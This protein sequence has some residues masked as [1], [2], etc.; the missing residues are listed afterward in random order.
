MLSSAR[1]AALCGQA[2]PAAYTGI[3][4]IRV[5]DPATQVV[6]QVFFI[7]DPASTETSGAPLGTPGTALDLSTTPVNIHGALPDHVSQPVVIESADWVTDLAT[8]RT[9][10]EIRVEQPGDFSEYALTV[11]HDA[12]DWVFRTARFS[13]KQACPTRFDCQQETEC[14]PERGPRVNVDYTARDFDSLRSAVLD[15]AAQHYPHWGERVPADGGVMLIEVLCAL[16]DEFSYMQDR[17]ARE[18]HFATATQRRSLHHMARLVDYDVDQGSSATT[19]LTL[20]LADGGGLNVA[21]VVRAGEPLVFWA[22]TESTDVVPFEVLVPEQIHDSYGDDHFWL[23]P[24]WNEMLAYTPDAANPCIPEGS[25]SLYIAPMADGR[26]PL[27]ETL[28]PESP[29]SEQENWIGRTLILRMD[30]EDPSRPHRVWVV[31]VTEVDVFRDP[32][33]EAEAG[34][35]FEVTK[36]TWSTDQALPFE[37]SLPDAKIHG[38]NVTAVAGRTIVK[39]VRTGDAVPATAQQLQQAVIREGARYESAVEETVSPRGFS[40]RVGLEETAYGGLAFSEAGIPYVTVE[41]VDDLSPT[42]T[43]LAEWS[44]TESLL[45]ADEEDEVFT[46]ESGLWTE[47]RRFQRG[48]ETVRHADYASNRGFTVVFGDGVF[49]AR[50]AEDLVLRLTYRLN[51]GSLGD[52]PSR[53]I[54]ALSE[55]GSGQPPLG[56]S[57]PQIEACTN[58]LPAHGGRDPE[59]PDHIRRFAPHVYRARPLRAVIDEDYQSIL[60]GLSFAQSI[61]V[62]QRWTGSWLTRFVTADP[63]D[64]NH[65]SDERREILLNAAHSIRQVGRHIAAVDPVYRPIDL[66]ITICVRSDA[67]FGQVKAAVLDALVKR[68]SGASKGLFHPDHF[69]FGTPLSRSSIEAVVQQVP[70]VLGVERICVRPH[71]GLNWREFTESSIEVGVREIVQVRNDPRFPDQGTISIYDHQQALQLTECSA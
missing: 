57:F 20:T 9:V 10:L 45:E 23:H 8:G 62:K 21:P 42:A 70:G 2:L 48:G 15:F 41:Q 28:D 24:Q 18:A 29:R 7:V 53:V 31:T 19:F 52:V 60:G 25:T 47:I 55:P 67:Y 43:V 49:G 26:S 22:L 51:P 34:G 4:F 64:S 33:V 46:L 30:P 14:A 12:V 44:Y 6:L 40:H 37:L 16:A 39:H 17:M 1:R 63:L 61:G 66:A 13:F 5:A 59:T 56:G 38:N 71:P 65:L 58:W 50:P 11:E 32:L 3:D 54:T 69:S 35:L 36:I 27:A 68:G